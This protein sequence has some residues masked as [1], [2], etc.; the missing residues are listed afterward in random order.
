MCTFQVRPHVFLFAHF[1][2]KYVEILQSSVMLNF[3][4]FIFDFKILPGNPTEF[5][6]LMF[7]N[8]HDITE[9][10]FWGIPSMKDSIFKCF[11]LYL[12]F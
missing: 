12:T 11:L 9:G 10:D 6:D 4:I 1:I 5:L 7:S 3:L 2:L 8:L